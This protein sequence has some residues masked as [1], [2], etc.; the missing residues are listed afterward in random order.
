MAIPFSMEENMGLHWNFL[1]GCG[2]VIL[3]LSPSLLK[4]ER[5]GIL[6]ANSFW[7]YVQPEINMIQIKLNILENVLSDFKGSCKMKSFSLIVPKGTPSW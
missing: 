1:A 6:P 2:V 3:R 7:A 5:T 4:I